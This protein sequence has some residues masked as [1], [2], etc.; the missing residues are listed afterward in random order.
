M[1]RVVSKIAPDWWDY[2]TLNREL[3]DA[4]AALTLKDLAQMGRPG[5]KV[6]FYDT[7]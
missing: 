2:T 4:A 6:K 1:S 7:V 5:F 3:L